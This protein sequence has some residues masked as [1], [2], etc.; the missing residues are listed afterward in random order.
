MLMLKCNRLKEELNLG[1]EADQLIAQNRTEEL[2]D[3]I[4]GKKASLG[5][6]TKL[7]A[8][9]YVNVNRRPCD[10]T[11]LEDHISSTHTGNRMLCS[12]QHRD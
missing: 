4:R 12:G 10:N 6:D 11:S 7:N 5:Q 2:A 8:S 1:P 3:L 9:D